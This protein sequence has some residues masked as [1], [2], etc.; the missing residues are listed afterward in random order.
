M[1]CPP[2][3]PS[4][5]CPSTWIIY[6]ISRNFIDGL[7]HTETDVEE[8]KRDPIKVMFANDF[9]DEDPEFAVKARNAFSALEMGMKTS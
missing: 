2:I 9:A 8:V 4:W 7:E 1:P 5:G 3:R 6:S